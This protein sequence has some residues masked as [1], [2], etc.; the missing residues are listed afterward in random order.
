M[1]GV[2]IYALIAVTLAVIYFVKDA[3]GNSLKIEGLRK[4]I[5]AYRKEKRALNILELIME[6]PDTVA[7]LRENERKLR[8]LLMKLRPMRSKL[9]VFLVEAIQAKVADNHQT[10]KRMYD[11]YR[12]MPVIKKESIIPTNKRV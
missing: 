12:G 6:E 8:R 9:E 11:E 1:E 4:E 2:H 5:E 3:V 10:E 7:A